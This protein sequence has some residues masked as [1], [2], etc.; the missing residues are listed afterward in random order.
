MKLIKTLTG[1]R[2]I[3]LLVGQVLRT[4]VITASIIAFVG[5]V[6]Y[7]AAHGA[8]SVPDYS[9][10]TGEGQEF[11][12]FTGIF[13][14]LATFKPSAVIQFGALILLATPILRVFFS[15]I[16]FVMEKDRMYI[17]ITLIVLCIIFF[18]MFGGLKV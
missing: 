2:D 14:G 15:L 9:N 16:G 17:F 6:L 12:T 18:S 7:L 4:G 8:D 3:A 11:T 1:D 10:F 13:A 5:G